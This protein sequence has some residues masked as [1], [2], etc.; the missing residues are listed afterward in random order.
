MFE[1]FQEE[2]AQAVPSTQCSEFEKIQRR[3]PAQKFSRGKEVG[4]A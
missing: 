4:I 3:L 1:I 2:K